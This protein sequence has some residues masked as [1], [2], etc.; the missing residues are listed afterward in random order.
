MIPFD[1][2]LAAGLVWPDP[3]R[4]WTDVASTRLMRRSERAR[5]GRAAAA[6]KPVRGAA[7]ADRTQR[8]E[9]PLWYRNG[10]PHGGDRCKVLP[11]FPA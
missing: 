9:L 11:S 2:T 10:R 8:V 6:R 5:L 7:D 1:K 3:A 4:L